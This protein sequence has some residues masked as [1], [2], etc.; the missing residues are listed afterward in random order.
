MRVGRKLH[1]NTLATDVSLRRARI[2]RRSDALPCISRDIALHLIC[3]CA[4][5]N[6]EPTVRCSR[7]RDDPT[8]WRI[9]EK[10]DK[11]VAG[12]SVPEHDILRTSSVSDGGMA[13]NRHPVLLELI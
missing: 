7:M 10:P 3:V 13:T 8:D 11:K 9:R 4:T 1:C 5:C 6:A 2:G 12:D